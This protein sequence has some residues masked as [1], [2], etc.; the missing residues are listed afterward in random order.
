MGSPERRMM[1]QLTIH[2]KDGWRYLFSPAHGKADLYA[3]GT[4]RKLVDPATDEIIVQYK[5]EYDAARLI[6]T[7]PESS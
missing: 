1:N 5:V 6:S 2:N 7:R 3:R 4:E